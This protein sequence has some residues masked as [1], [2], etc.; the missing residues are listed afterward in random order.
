MTY[1]SRFSAEDGNS[2][3]PGTEGA[4]D[5]FQ[6]DAAINTGMSTKVAYTEAVYLSDGPRRHAHNPSVST[7][8][9]GVGGSRT[10]AAL[11]Q[12]MER[13]A[14]DWA[15]AGVEFTPSVFS[16]PS[17]PSSAA[18]SVKSNTLKK[19]RR[20]SMKSDVPA[21]V[22]TLASS[23][24]HGDMD[25]MD[26]YP[27]DAYP[28]SDADDE[29]PISRSGMA[30]AGRVKSVGRVRAP[31]KATP[32]PIVAKH[33]MTRGSI[34]IQPITVPPSGFSSEVQ[35]VQ[36]GSSADSYNSEFKDRP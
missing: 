28:V 36:G 35:I 3:T 34:Y 14:A 4:E 7:T 29:L 2:S 17:A 31:R 11:L 8:G 13:P 9:P 6:Y 30:T 24:L 23:W 18:P 19:K 10:S 1:V 5:P 22:N 25:A 12:M 26:A 27:V 21:S 32:A 33:G 16:G 20:P 15:P